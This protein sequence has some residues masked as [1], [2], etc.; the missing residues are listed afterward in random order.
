MEVVGCSEEVLEN[1]E[2]SVASLCFHFF[3]EFCVYFVVGQ[4]CF[5]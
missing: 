2:G 4:E 5:P 1:M 3:F